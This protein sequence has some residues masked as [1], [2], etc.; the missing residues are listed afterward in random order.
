M[1]ESQ[2][3]LVL[4]AKALNENS[5]EAILIGNMAAALHGAPVATIDIDLF[6]R[7]TPRNMQKLKLVADAL[8]AVILRRYYPASRVTRL[9]RQ[10]DGLQ[11]NFFNR[12]A[13]KTFYDGI[14]ARA[15]VHHICGQRL[16]AATPDDIIR[17]KGAADKSAALKRESDRALIELI[18]YRLSLPPEKRLNCLRRKIGLRATCL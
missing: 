13:G 15:D 16:L 11:L 6:F 3:E 14:R 18:R 1:M 5:L 8:E 17:I 12:I 9:R 2:P 7:K 4:V 10:R